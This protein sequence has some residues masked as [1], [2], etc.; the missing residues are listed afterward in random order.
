AAFE[1]L[2]LE[3]RANAVREHRYLELVADLPELEHLLAR[4][5]LRFVDQHAMQGIL[6]AAGFDDVEQVVGRGERRC[7]SVEADARSDAPYSVPIV[8]MR[9]KQQRVHT[10]LAVVVA[11]LQKRGRLARVHR[12]VIEVELRHCAGFRLARALRAR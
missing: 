6:A 4:E 11:R 5:K 9:R 8:E 10:A 3:V 12:G 7:G 1:G 2:T